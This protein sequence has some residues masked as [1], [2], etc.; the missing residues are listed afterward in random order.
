MYPAV[1]TV[2]SL[3]RW[4]L[5]VFALAALVPP[6]VDWLRGTSQARSRLTGTLLVAT[7]DVQLLAGLLLFFA[8]SPVT[9]DAL[10]HWSQIARDPAWTYW[11]L[12]H[13]LLG[14]TAIVLAH[15]GQALAKRAPDARSADRR[16]ALFFGAAALAIAA[17]TPW[18][19][20]AVGR[21]LWPY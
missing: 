2:H 6:W 9:R 4:A 15:V 16:A 13:P 20:L 19:F 21:P 17:A 14:I 5:L 10:A 18:P 3:L 1:L 7:L 11:A 12:A 8:L